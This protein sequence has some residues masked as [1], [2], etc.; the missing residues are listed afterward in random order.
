MVYL[1][2]QFICVLWHNKSRSNKRFP[3]FTCGK[4]VYNSKLLK[5]LALSRSLQTYTGSDPLSEISKNLKESNQ[6]QDEESI[7]AQNFK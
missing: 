3:G 6:V 7:E 1:D 5:T 2:V 4:L